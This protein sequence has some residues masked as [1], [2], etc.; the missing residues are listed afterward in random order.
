MLHGPRSGF[1]GPSFDRSDTL[2]LSGA[3]PIVLSG[4]GRVLARLDRED[5]PLWRA[6]SDPSRVRCHALIMG[7][8]RF[9]SVTIRD[10]RRSSGTHIQPDVQSTRCDLNQKYDLVESSKGCQ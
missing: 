8:I 5:H 7:P 6:D 2:F 3:P 10:R 1:L 4:R 9:Q